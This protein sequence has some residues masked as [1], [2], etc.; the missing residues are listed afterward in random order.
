VVAEHSK[1]HV[2]INI[3]ISTVTSSTMRSHNYS[4][5]GHAAGPIRRSF[6]T[7]TTYKPT[8]VISQTSTHSHAIKT[9]YTSNR[10][11]SLI[12][13]SAAHLLNGADEL[14]SRESRNRVDEVLRHAWADS[15]TTSYSS[16]VR[17]FTNF[18]NSESVPLHLRLPA[19]E[20]LLCNF[21]ASFAGRHSSGT[22]YSKFAALKAWHN[23]QGVSW[24]G[25]ARLRCVLNGVKNMAPSSSKMSLR[26]PI[27]IA[28][29][30]CLLDKLDLNDPFDLVVA[31]A[32][33]VA[34]WD[35]CRLGEL[36][37]T[38]GSS[39][40]PSSIPARSDVSRSAHDK[41]SMTLHLPRTKT[42]R[43]GQDVVIVSQLAPLN[44][45][46]LLLK[47]FRVNRLPR[48]SPLFAY[49]S[50]KG[51]QVLT[52]AKFLRRCNDI[53][54]PRGF[55]RATGHCFRI[56][57]TTQLL[58]SG[59]PPDVVKVTGRWSSDSFLRY[60]RAL[61]IIAPLHLKNIPY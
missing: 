28:M 48:S 11:K 38:S 46:S 33:V 14:C 52:K 58:L 19:N 4:S 6:Q 7:F 59:V 22:V 44:P 30:T 31:C 37:P 50:S 2:T 23:V 29:L 27:T 54:S 9:S 51:P 13:Q 17:Q 40:D 53:W 32:A 41:E 47:H 24:E 49:R 26:S 35:Q 57:G 10:K 56:G 3:L 42:H 21:A 61:D 16:A 20:S 45:V 15:T 36:L 8:P 25:S 5:S 43:L 1:S 12:F 60:W 55:P 18:C 39:Y 34:F